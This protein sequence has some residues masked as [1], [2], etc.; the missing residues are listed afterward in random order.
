MDVL[1]DYV[2]RTADGAWCGVFVFARSGQL[3]GLEVWSA[4]GTDAVSSLPAI[5]QSRPLQAAG[6]A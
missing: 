4:D 6:N 2:W 3:A 1:A 5:E